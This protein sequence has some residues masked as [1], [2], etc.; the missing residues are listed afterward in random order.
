[1]AK[2]PAGPIVEMSLAIAIAIGDNLYTGNPSGP[3]ESIKL[4]L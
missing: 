1:M 4:L 2:Y 3:G